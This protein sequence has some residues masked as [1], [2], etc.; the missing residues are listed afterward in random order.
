[1]R[2]S[3]RSDPLRE[4]KINAFIRTKSSDDDGKNM[5]SAKKVSLMLV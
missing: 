3:E 5:Q 4:A 1:M 2:P